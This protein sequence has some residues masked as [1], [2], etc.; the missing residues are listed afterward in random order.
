MNILKRQVQAKGRCLFVAVPD[1]Y[2]E[3]RRTLELFDHWYPKICSWPLALV[4]QDGMEDLDLPWNFLQAIFIG[5]TVEWK[6]SKDARAIAVTAKM[7]GKWVHV[8]RVNTP[9]R[10]DKWSELADSI[11]GTGISKFTHMRGKLLEK[12]MF[13]DPA[14]IER[15]Y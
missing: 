8:G 2:A 4:A 10:Y 3:G 6:N 15:V 7:M 13:G 9:N 11:D 1:L 5:G 14:P 12:S